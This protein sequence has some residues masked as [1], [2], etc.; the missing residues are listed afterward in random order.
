MMTYRESKPLAASPTQG[1]GRGKRQVRKA[2]RKSK[3][4]AR[5]VRG[6]CAAF[7]NVFIR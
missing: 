5:K 4:C 6:I 2:A 3:R 1:M 7:G